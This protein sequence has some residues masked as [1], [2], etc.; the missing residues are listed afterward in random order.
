LAGG[1]LRQPEGAPHGEGAALRRMAGTIPMGTP[2]PGQPVVEQAPAGRP[3][4]VPV[5][6]PGGQPDEEEDVTGGYDEAMFAP[7]DRADEPITH[8]APFGPGASFVMLPYENERSFQV[9]V[10]DQLE[11]SNKAPSLKA[12]IDKLR[13]GG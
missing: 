6:G 7:T 2:G 4:P 1:D 3:Q 8:G 12:Y 10:A 9:R 11:S 13:A 5:D